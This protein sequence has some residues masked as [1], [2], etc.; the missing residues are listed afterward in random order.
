MGTC[1]VGEKEET[2][3]RGSFNKPTGKK[4]SKNNFY[5]EFKNDDN[6]KTE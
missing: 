6:N 2:P 1:C 3:H 5:S 4:V